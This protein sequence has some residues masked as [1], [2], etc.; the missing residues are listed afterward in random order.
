MEV[1]FIKVLLNDLNIT[2]NDISKIQKGWS[3]KQKYIVT[4]DEEVFNL[5]IID[6]D[7]FDRYNN[8]FNY[9]KELYNLGVKV[10]K[11][12]DIFIY[13]NKGVALYEFI[14]G[15]DGEAI[16]STLSKQNQ[17]DIGFQAGLELKKIHSI[18]PPTPVD[19]KKIKIRKHNRY[20]EIYKNVDYKIKSENKILKLI[21]SNLDVL[22]SRDS[23][24]QHDDYH[25]GN[26]IIDN[27][28]L[29]GIID[30]DLLD[31]G[32][33]YHDFIK[34]GNISVCTS[35]YFCKGQIDGYFS[36]QK[37]NH[38]FW[39][40]YSVYGAMSVISSVAWLKKYHPSRFEEGM[41]GINQMLDDHNN[42]KN[43]VP[44]WYKGD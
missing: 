31:F 14:Q 36:P 43:I 38:S 42:F 10:A 30:F 41:E 9:Q 17:Y 6:G 32:D 11:P 26:M 18:K 24:I 20:L 8:V 2:Y 21:E 4:T 7:K 40:T 23:T 37:P 3:S 25:L 13:K 19:W 29:V 16:I 15:L 28:K 12:I 44:K 22:D 1:S 5:T 27:G 34:A 33:P 39:L 35:E